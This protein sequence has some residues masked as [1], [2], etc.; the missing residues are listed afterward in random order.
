MEPIW[1]LVGGKARVASSLTM[2]A[3][4]SK[5]VGSVLC[6][7]CVGSGVE[8]GSLLA[9]EPKSMDRASPDSGQ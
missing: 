3:C 5:T 1:F 8:S 9:A 6:C 7:C 4:S 2:A